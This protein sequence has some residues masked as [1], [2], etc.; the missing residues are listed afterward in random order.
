MTWL[1]RLIQEIRNRHPSVIV[2]PEV[3][4]SGRLIERLRAGSL[5]L[6]VCPDSFRSDD[7]DALALDSVEYAWMCSP[8]YPVGT[9]ELTLKDLARHTVIV[10]EHASGLGDLVQRWLADHG[11]AIP[12]MITSSNLT[13]LEALALSG[14]GISY[15]PRRALSHLVASGRLNIINSRPA[16]PRIPYVCMTR[17]SSDDDFLRFVAET[18]MTVCDFSAR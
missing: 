6:V 2:G 9:T 7:L 13:A 14:L 3:D 10:Q 12:S 18:A 8:G 15:L 5:D 1:P 17:K 4:A 11:V 16:L